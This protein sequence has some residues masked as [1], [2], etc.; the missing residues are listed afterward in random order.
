MESAAEEIR[1]DLAQFAAMIVGDYVKRASESG[2]GAAARLEESVRILERERRKI[3]G[4][5]RELPQCMNLLAD[6]IVGLEKELERW[7]GDKFVRVFGGYIPVK[8]RFEEVDKGVDPVRGVEMTN[9]KRSAPRWGSSPGSSNRWNGENAGIVVK[10]DGREF[11]FQMKPRMFCYGGGG[12]GD[13]F[14]AFRSPSSIAANYNQERPR[15]PGL[16]DHAPAMNRGGFILP[17]ITDGYRQTR[18]SPALPN[19]HRISHVQQQ[20][21]RKARLCWS[22]DLHRRFLS[23]L[24]QLGGARVATPKQIREVMKVDGLSNDEVKS[25]LQKYRLQTK[26]PDPTP[27]A[28]AESIAEEQ[29][30]GPSDPTSSR[31][32]SPHSS[33]SN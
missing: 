1:S 10:E 13:A 23:A 12:G 3:A 14:V 21:P 28:Q 30:S 31:S 19:N 8:R 6:V 16:F 33:S 18:I 7:R 4:F 29:Q 2:E 22:P 32:A 27:M 20:E 11:D 26:K 25:H 24:D 9:W 15:F 5:K 17:P